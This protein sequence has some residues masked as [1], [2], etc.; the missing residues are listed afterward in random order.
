MKQ[1]ANEQYKDEHKKGKRKHHEKRF[2][3]IGL[4]MDN[5]FYEDFQ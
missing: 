2:S 3:Y 5:Y 4:K 1:E